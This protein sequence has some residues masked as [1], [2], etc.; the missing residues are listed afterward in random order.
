MK[1]EEGKETVDR[2]Y[3][4]SM[5]NPKA[6]RKEFTIWNMAGAELKI[7]KRVKGHIYIVQA[8]DGVCR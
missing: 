3:M 2:L 6:L 7:V 8:L 4:E 1:G 5:V